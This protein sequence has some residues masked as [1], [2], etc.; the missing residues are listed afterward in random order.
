MDDIFWQAE[1]SLILYRVIR[2]QNQKIRV[3]SYDWLLQM[4]ICLLTTIAN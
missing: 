4:Q 1:K 3:F 2:A